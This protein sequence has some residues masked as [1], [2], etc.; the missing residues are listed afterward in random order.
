MDELEKQIFGGL[1]VG[2]QARAQA[3]QSGC[4]VCR[5]VDATMEKITAQR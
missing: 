4:Y 1:P 3:A 2:R 5:E